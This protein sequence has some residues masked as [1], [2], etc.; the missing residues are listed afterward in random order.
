MGR[1]RREGRREAFA[2]Q[3]RNLIRDSLLGI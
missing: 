3:I 1:V 2:D